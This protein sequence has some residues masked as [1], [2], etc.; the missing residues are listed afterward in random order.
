MQCLGRSSHAER[1]KE[2]NDA[3]VDL[4]PGSSDTPERAAYEKS[5]A[6]KKMQRFR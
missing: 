2:G 6:F 5:A 1:I 4:R 3:P